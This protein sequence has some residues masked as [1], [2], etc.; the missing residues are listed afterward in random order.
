MNSTDFPSGQ[1][2]REGKSVQHFNF[3]R[4][5]GV[6]PLAEIRMMSPC[7]YW[8]IYNSVICIPTCT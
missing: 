7:E 1:N 3:T 6:P 4:D 2:L 8:P 5:S